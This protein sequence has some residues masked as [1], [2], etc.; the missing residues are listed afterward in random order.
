MPVADRWAYLDHA[1]V[2]PLSGPARDRIARWADE[3]CREGD[4][5]W[6]NWSQEVEVF[7]T[8]AARMIGASPAEIALVRNTTWGITLVA[9]GFPWQPGD[10]VVTLADEFPSNQ[11][12]WLNLAERGVETR[13]VP[14]DQGRVDLGRVA[15][16]IDARTRIFSL[17]WVGYANG[18]R[19]D[20]NTAV[21][22]AHDRGVLVFLDAIQALGVFPIDV[23]DTPV[24]FL[25]ADGHKW[26]LGPEGAGVLFVRQE[27]LERLRPVGVGWHSVAVPD[28][29]RIELRFKPSAIRFEGGSDNLAG[30]LGLK[31]SV[32][33]LMQ[34]GQAAI[35][36][37]VLEIT[38]L[39]CRRLAEV[40][41]TVHS[42][43]APEHASGIVSFSVPGRDPVELRNKC[44]EHHVA[45]SCRAG[46]LR[47]SP[48]AYNNA[49]DIERLVDVL[50]G[51]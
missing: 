33:L 2:A 21:R 49:E 22:M 45:L 15:A 24:D 50:R 4:P 25:A 31:A 18:W 46:R 51:S 35:S 38:Q 43:R 16:A 47:I 8:S 19:N 7:R 39:A 29:T 37:R 36:R 11:Y 44:L 42:D 17:S 30:F 28:F 41:A 13:R 6:G 12:P 9:E 1:A 20:L 34:Y 27:Q 14:V 48:H 5:A 40:G 10:N 23:A 3:A 32:D 26:L